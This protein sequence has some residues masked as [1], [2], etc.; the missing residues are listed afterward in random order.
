M[1]HNDSPYNAYTVHLN[2][3][4]C[5]IFLC[6]LDYIFIPV[7][8]SA[9]RTDYCPMGFMNRSGSYTLVVEP[10]KAFLLKLGC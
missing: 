8:C 6:R 10:S 3:R 2:Y 5:Y 4:Y 9:F 1:V 7:G